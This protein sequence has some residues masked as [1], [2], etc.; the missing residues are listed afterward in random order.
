[1]PLRRFSR[2]EPIRGSATQNFK[3]MHAWTLCFFNQ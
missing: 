1:M 3:T 2:I